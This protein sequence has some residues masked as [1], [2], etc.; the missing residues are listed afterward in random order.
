MIEERKA[1]EERGHEARC[2]I[3]TGKE[4]ARALK[5]PREISDILKDESTFVWFDLAQP[6]PAD[7]KLLQD[8]F[9]LHPMAIEDAALSHER[10]KIDTY[11]RYLLLVVHGAS[12]DLR[13]R[14]TINELAI[15]AGTNFLVTIRSEPL[16]PLDEI[17]RRW[18][19]HWGPIPRDAIGL[20]YVILDTI[21]DGYYP[22]TDAYDSRIDRIEDHLFAEKRK[23]QTVLKEIFDFKRDLQAFRRSAAPVREILTPILRGDVHQLEP[24]VLAYYRDVYDH[25]IRVIDQIDAQRDLVNTTL[26]IHLSSQSHRQGETAKQLTIIATIFLPLTYITGFF[27]QNFDYLVK[28][29]AAPSAF[30][31]FGVGT[32]LTA[33]GALLV[34]FRYKRWF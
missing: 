6:S 33:L 31:W 5:D 28:G 24:T 2:L 13:G 27:G 29:I 34:Y 17:E 8:E 20:L 9:A 25:A 30:W 26:D 14:L 21:V 32:Q 19:A 7:L 22:I 16:L 12:L 3:F 1:P 11:E 10:P 23:A 18:M 4:A 15:F